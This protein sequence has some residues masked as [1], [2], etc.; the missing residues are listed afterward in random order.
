VVSYKCFDYR[1]PELTFNPVYVNAISEDE[2]T[3]YHES[4]KDVIDLDAVVVVSSSNRVVS[5]SF[6]QQWS[7]L[8]PCND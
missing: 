4:V 2:R 6:V 3:T 8:H 1:N 5:P 7:I